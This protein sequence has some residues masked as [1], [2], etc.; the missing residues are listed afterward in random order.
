MDTNATVI[1]VPAYELPGSATVDVFAEDLTTHNLYTVNFLIG[2]VGTG[3]LQTT[4]VTIYPNPARGILHIQNASGAAI[5]ITSADGISIRSIA[6]FHG[7]TLDINDL[8]PGLYLLN[9]ERTDGSV[10]RKKVV[11]H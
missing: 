11:V 1:I 2:G 4:P 7:T 3:I 10:V 5:Q 9:I 8:R 6:S